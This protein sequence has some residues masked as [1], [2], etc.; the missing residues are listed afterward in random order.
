MKTITQYLSLVLMVLMAIPAMAQTQRD[1]DNFRYRDQRGINQFEAPKDTTSTFDGLHVRVGGASTIQFQSLTQEN[2]G[3]VELVDL[4]SNFNLATANLDLDVALYEGVRMHLRT[5]LSSQHHNESYVKGGYIQIDKL[6]FISEG[7]AEGLMDHLRVKIGHMENNYGDGH[8]RRT[9]NA[10]SIYNPFVGNYLMDAFTTEVGAEVYYFKGPWLGMIGFTNGK[11]NQNVS[12][13]DQTSPSFMAKFGYDNAFSDNARFRLTGSVYHS[14]HNAARGVYLYRGDRAGSRYYEVLSDVDGGGDGFRGGMVVPDFRNE[15]TSFMINPFVKFGGLEFFGI[16]ET[17]TGK[18]SGESDTRS[19]NQFSG[20]L[21]YR[22]GNDED[23]HIGTRYNTV[24]GDL[25]TG[26]EIDVDR[27]QL[28]AGWYMTKNI[29]M[30]LEYV[31]QNYDG[32]PASDIHHEGKFDGLMVEAA[33][34]F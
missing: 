18:D 30:K 34:S 4:G 25:K 12:D 5:Y 22:F 11:L 28:G 31:T 26:G 23:F 8:F 16:I 3:P 2:D 24:S 9:D 7:F 13:K 29:L 19:Y 1:L 14:A 33:I 21:I 10:Q 17:A 20:E 15:M 27:F 32:Y 6:D